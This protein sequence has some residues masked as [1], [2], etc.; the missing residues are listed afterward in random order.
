MMVGCFL[1][2]DSFIYGWLHG[3][4]GGIPFDDKEELEFP[5]R[6]PC[7]GVEVVWQPSYIY[8]LRFIYGSDDEA[9]WSMFRGNYT[10]NPSSKE[11]FMMK[12]GE[13][14]IQI[15][16][17]VGTQGWSVGGKL[18]TFVLGIRFGT[19]KERSSR[20]YGSRSGEKKVE[21]H[22]GYVFGY[23]NGRAGILID[24]IQVVWQSQGIHILIHVIKSTYVFLCRNGKGEWGK[25]FHS[26]VR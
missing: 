16:T 5:D 13:R 8:A 6:T 20:V 9:G 4:I 11:K 19:N 14:I 26:V 25:S 2:I 7:V 24:Q 23:A 22:D 12:P 17:Y 21:T 3:D 18:I 10:L 15:T 1:F